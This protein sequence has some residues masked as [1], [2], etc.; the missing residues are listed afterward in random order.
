MLPLRV[1]LRVPVRSA[2]LLCPVFNRAVLRSR[3]PGCP[4]R[5]S[6]SLPDRLSSS[7]ARLPDRLR[8]C[9]STGLS[10]YCA[11]NTTR[12]VNG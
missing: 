8:S 12:R 2:A 3:M 9:R 5:L 6:A 4:S 7:P 1:A 10:A 11:C